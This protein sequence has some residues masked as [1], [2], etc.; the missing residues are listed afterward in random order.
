MAETVVEYSTLSG[1][2]PRRSHMRL[3]DPE[4]TSRA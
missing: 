1:H 4:Q 3:F 2:F